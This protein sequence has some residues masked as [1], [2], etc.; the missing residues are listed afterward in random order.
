MVVTMYEPLAFAD[1]TRLTDGQSP[2]KARPKA[3]NYSKIPNVG[4]TFATG[5]AVPLK[6]IV[7]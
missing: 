1:Q 6:V 4:S 5:A 7:G 2:V 3:G